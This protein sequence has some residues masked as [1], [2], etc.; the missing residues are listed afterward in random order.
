M[1]EENKIKVLV[2]EDN[3]DHSFLV[4]RA[5]EKTPAFFSVKIVDNIEGCLELI[6]KEE[7]HIIISDYK[8]PGFS[9]L[10]LLSQLKKKNIDLPLVMLTG[11]GNE[12]IAVKA[13][14]EGA[15]DYVIKEP[16]YFKT[17]PLVI[18]RALDRYRDKKEKKN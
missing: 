3:H 5:L 10:Q 9:G 2:V 1:N 17:I 15:Y 12:E 18:K 6:Q 13:M 16:D 14:K 8:L 11:S 4:K 7:F